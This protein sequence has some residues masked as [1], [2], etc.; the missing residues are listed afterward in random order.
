MRFD[1]EK[2]VIKEDGLK[3]EYG[4][5]HGNNRGCHHVVITKAGAGGSYIGY[6]EK[7]LKIARRHRD[8]HGCT[9]LCLSNYASDSFEHGDVTVIRELLA[10]VVGDRTVET[11]VHKSS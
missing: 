4:L 9:V 8:S 2:T 5:I 1:T 10:G 6:E 7:Y 11:D 3:I